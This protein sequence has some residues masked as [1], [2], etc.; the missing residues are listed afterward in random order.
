MLGNV[1]CL[2]TPFVEI[3]SFC[4]FIWQEFTCVEYQKGYTTISIVPTDSKQE[5]YS[6]YRNGTIANEWGKE[7]KDVPYLLL[8]K[9]L[10]NIVSGHAIN[11]ID[12]NRYITLHSAALS[13]NNSGILILG[14]S[15]N[16][17][18][19]MTLEMVA[20]HNWNYLSDE[21]GLL[22]PQHIIYP[23]LKTISCKQL[24]LVRL[25]E[26]WPVRHFGDDHQITV[27]REKHGIPVPLKAIIF[28]KYSPESQSC[29]EPVKKSDALLRLLNAQIG[30]AHF[31]ATV[32]QMAA[33]VKNIDS[34]ILR[35]NDCAKAAGMI[36]K[37][38]KE[39]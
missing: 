16:G 29:L 13:K 3:N 20:N 32:E 38:M 15:G 11:Q 27:P 17:K 9:V 31:T 12:K 14:E 19:T 10:E 23:F 6:V 24:G 33:V 2:E 34:Y 25:D 8:S 18:S 1:L 35:H 4:D 36:D 30:R 5:F 28:V 22:D 7:L 37:L 26:A 39:I 21:V